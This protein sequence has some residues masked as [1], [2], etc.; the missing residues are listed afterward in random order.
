MGKL[1][2]NAPELNYSGLY[3]DYFKVMDLIYHHCEHDWHKGI[4][5]EEILRQLPDLPDKRIGWILN[6]LKQTGRIYEPFDG[7]YRVIS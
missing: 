6:W 5:R 2:I 7:V 4:K 3:G 1:I